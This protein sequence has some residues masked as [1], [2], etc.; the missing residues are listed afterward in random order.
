MERYDLILVRAPVQSPELQA[1][2]RRYGVDA[3]QLQVNRPV[4]Q[5][6]PRLEA[7]SLGVV[8]EGHGGLVR[9]ALREEPG[10]PEY[11][12]T[13]VFDIGLLSEE[14]PFI[15]PPTRNSPAVSAPLPPED[16]FDIGLPRFSGAGQTGRP[17]GPRREDHPSG[18]FPSVG[19]TGSHPAIGGSGL[20]STSSGVHG[21]T[22]NTGSHP[23]MGGSGLF[24]TSSGVHGGMGRTGSHSAIGGSGM[25]PTASGSHPAIG[26]SGSWVGMSGVHPLEP[27][28]GSQAGQPRGPRRSVFKGRGREDSGA[29]RSDASSFFDDADD[30]VL[31]ADIPESPEAFFGAPLGAEEKAPKQAPAP[32]SSGVRPLASGVGHAPAP[33]WLTGVAPSL[34]TQAM[35]PGELKPPPPPGAEPNLDTTG[36]EL[37]TDY[38]GVRWQPSHIPEDTVARDMA[39]AQADLSGRQRA[40]VVGPGPPRAAANSGL[41]LELG[42]AA[43]APAAQPPAERRVLS[44]PAAPAADLDLD[45]A[46][47]RVP[48]RRAR[49]GTASGLTAN[50]RRV[51]GPTEGGGNVRRARPLHDTGGRA[52]TVPFKGFLPAVPT[53]FAFPLRGPAAT[54]YITI[55]I[56][57]FLGGFAMMAA[58]LLLIVGLIVVLLVLAG[59]L[60]INVHFFSTCLTSAAHGNPHPGDMPSFSSDFKASLLFPGLSMLTFIGLTM[61][62]AVLVASRSAAAGEPA[63]AALIAAL[64]LAPLLYYPAGLALVAGSGSSFALWD[65]PRA[66]RGILRAPHLYLATIGL[67]FVAS[68]LPGAVAAVVYWVLSAAQLDLIGA[69]LGGLISLCGGTYAIG[70]TGALLG[71]MARARPGIWD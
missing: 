71:H 16:A 66:I 7:R 47:G 17:P 4:L 11:E 29:R 3:T 49:A 55:G 67:S 38:S 39:D 33:D 37:E 19:A 13:G 27:G 24:S 64:I 36:L 21:G 57:T 23:A 52:V 12:P 45:P 63:S 32:S 59:L 15:G 20:F 51:P 26:G 31:P 56:L 40:R 5:D 58:S 28:S 53:A 65:I 18:F 42:D 70:V 8:I 48:A 2:L 25:F 1:A 54:W 43:L 69:F 35:R 30:V 9:L 50:L 61:A 68:I 60:A 10:Q 14:N 44:P 41:E 22:G 46:S 62:P 34:V 6:V